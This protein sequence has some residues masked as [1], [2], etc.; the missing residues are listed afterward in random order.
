MKR[1]IFIVAMV[2]VGAFAT[3]A[4][5]G[6]YHNGSTLYCQDCHIAHGSQQ[7]GYSASGVVFPVPGPNAPYPELLR[8]EPNLLC[9]SCHNDNTSYPDVYGDNT[10]KNASD[11]RQAG[12]LS[13]VSAAG[14]PAPGANYVDYDAL[15]HGKGHTLWSTLTPPGY[16]DVGGTK[17]Y[18]PGDEGLECVNCHAQHGSVNYRN[19]LPRTAT[20]TY[21]STAI[22]TNDK[23]KGVFERQALRYRPEDVDFN[24]PDNTDSQYGTF[25]KQCH[26]NFHG[27]DGDAIMGEHYDGLGGAWVRHPT[28]G[29]NLGRTGQP[30]FVA[31]LATYLAKPTTNRV[32]MM[33]ENEQWALAAGA[34]SSDLTPSCF[35]CHKGHGNQNPFGL[36]FMRGTGTVTEQGDDGNLY[37][38][39]CKQC[40]VQ[41]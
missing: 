3:A 7:H 10:G 6:D 31:N 41:G 21:N 8:N 17:P 38:D 32:K 22:G 23:T 34:T 18:V 14:R 27:K 11:V 30:T 4:M 15:G 40:H 20:L 26:T 13:G 2:A 25:C 37:K 28:A 35:T 9:L 29:V 33:S 39:L 5:A 1:L 36:V 16:D 24:E 19:V 12:A